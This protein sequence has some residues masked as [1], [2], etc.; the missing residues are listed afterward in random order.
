M[1]P[2]T[3][4]GLGGMSC[5]P[6]GGKLDELFRTPMIVVAFQFKRLNGVVTS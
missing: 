1:Q 2:G 4:Y 5:V 3:S 6:L